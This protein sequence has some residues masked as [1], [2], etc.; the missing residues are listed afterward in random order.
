MHEAT[1]VNNVQG[2]AV[3]K[4]KAP[5]SVRAQTKNSEIHIINEKTSVTNCVRTKCGIKRR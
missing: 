3:P 5:V 4:I 1:V 2:R